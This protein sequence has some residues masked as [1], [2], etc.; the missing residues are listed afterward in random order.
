[1]SARETI[2]HQ[3]N[4]WPTYWSAIGRGEKT[5]EVRRNDRGFQ[6]GD[7]IELYRTWEDRPAST[8]KSDTQPLR[9]RIGWILQ[10]GQFG[11]EPGHCVFSLAP[12]D[13]AAP[14]P[15]HQPTGRGTGSE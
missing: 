7:I 9:F 3:L 11:I 5:F 4:T 1:M 14:P 15:R 8:R 13:A 2:V 6:T 12:I 10:G